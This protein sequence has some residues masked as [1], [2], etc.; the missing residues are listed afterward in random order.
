MAKVMVIIMLQ[1]LHSHT[2]YS[3][4]GADRPEEVVEAAI[5]AG[6]SLIGICDHQYGIMYGSI[7][8]FGLPVDMDVQPDFDRPLRRYFD[9]INLI[10]E[11]YSDKIRVLR[12]VELCTL[13]GHGRH[14]LPDGVDVSYFDY[15]LMET[16]DAPDSS[17]AHGDLFAFAERCG[18]KLGVAHT[19]MFRFIKSRGEDP[20]AYFVKM[21]ERGIF[22]EMNISH[23]SIHKYRE[24]PYMLAFFENEEQ[25]DIV[26]RSGVEISIGFDG[27]RVNEYPASR[28]V[29]YCRRAER[30]GLCF[31]FSE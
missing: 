22:W 7:G 29:D 15:A 4:C 8:F 19:D 21:R 20:Y 3:F 5:D 13:T 17:C 9:H 1:D 24:H 11:K 30:L 25:Q 23:D 6:L 16:L 12:G 14:A 18:C 31:A 2:Y 26:R 10:K 27:H 28:V